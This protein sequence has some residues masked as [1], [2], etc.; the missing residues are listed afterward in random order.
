M[1]WFCRLGGAKVR[2]YIFDQIILGM[3]CSANVL[4]LLLL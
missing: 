2:V 4:C 1:A 3:S